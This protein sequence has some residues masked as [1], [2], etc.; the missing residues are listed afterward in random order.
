M[1]KIILLVGAFLALFLVDVSASSKAVQ[2]VQIYSAPNADGKITSKTIDAALEAAGLR[3]DANNNM[4][5]PFELRFKKHHYETYR[6]AVVHS[7]ELTYKLIKKYPSIGLI[8]P[9]SMSIYSDDEKKTMNIATLTLA[10]MARI[11]QIPADNKD[12]IAYSQL[13]NKALAAALPNGHFKTLN[14]KVEDATK[15]LETSFSMEMER[16]E[17][18][19]IEEM[20]ED[21]QAEFEGELEPIGFLFPGYLNLKEEFSKRDFD[22]YDFYDT[23]SICKF[24]VIFPVS[25][26][27]PEVGAF[28]P[29]TFYMYKKKGEDVMHM[30]FPSVDNWISATDIEDKESIKPL[31]EAQKMLEDVV[32]ELI[33]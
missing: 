30:G 16:D 10:G 11:T 20:K 9:L 15:A 1:K 14:Y 32:N 24:D 25:K 5:N 21:F 17:D 6:L 29:C 12:L 33:E 13:L 7:S 22:E 27:H 8:T 3:V 28:A 26:L 19:D 18:D 4:N 23:Y 2:D 31:V